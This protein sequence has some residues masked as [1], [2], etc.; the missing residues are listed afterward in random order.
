MEKSSLPSIESKR[1]LI[2]TLWTDKTMMMSMAH[3][4]DTLLH[5]TREKLEDMC[6]TS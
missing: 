5:T 1:D 3:G 6:S 2:A 4:K